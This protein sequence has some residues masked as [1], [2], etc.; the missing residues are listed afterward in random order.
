MDGE[1]VGG[2][3]S[4]SDKDGDALLYTV[5]GD[6]AASFKTDHNGQISTK[7]K[8]DHETK[9][10]YMVMLTATDPSGANDHIMVT[11]TVTD[12]NDDASD[13]RL[14]C[15]RLQGDWYGSGRDV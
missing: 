14:H 5:S 11:V 2:P 15:G 8:L 6:D 4:A 3:I 13:N 10:T 12:E 9:D 7:V 1:P